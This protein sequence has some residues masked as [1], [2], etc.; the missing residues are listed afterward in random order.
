MKFCS[1]CGKELADGV[2]FCESCGTAVASDVMVDGAVIADA[3][4]PEPKKKKFVFSKKMGIIISAVLV[5]V[6]IAGIVIGNK[7]SL[8]Q[9]KEKLESA[10]DYMTYSALKAENY[11]SLQSKVWRNCIYEQSSTETDKYTKDEKGKFYD[12]FNDALS[13]F[14]SGEIITYMSVD[15]NVSA[16]NDLMSELKDCPEKYEDEYKAL[17]ELY[18][19]YSELT[20]LVV[21]S[22]TYSWTTFSEALESAKTHYKS[23]LSS[24]RL[25]LE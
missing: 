24:A 4:S 25:L 8:N 5:A 15:T 18:V 20:D 21:G 11:A 12:D 13:S 23:A 16:V 2:Q 3:A 1:N 14:Y 7:V 9:Y 10:Y 19:A 22:S 6:I 17:K